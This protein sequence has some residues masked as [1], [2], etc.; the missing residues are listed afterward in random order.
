[1]VRAV[2]TA[3]RAT[4]LRVFDVEAFVLAPAMG[5]EAYR[6]ALETG[7]E[8]GATH[9]SAIGT[10]ILGSPTLLDPAQRVDLFGRLCDE[11]ARFGLHVGVGFMLY[12]D[13]RTWDEALAL[14]E[15]ARPNAGL[16]LDP[17]HL[18]RA[19]AQ[20]GSLAHLPAHRVA[21]ARL[22]DAPAAAPPLD[23]LPTEARTARL[24]LGDGAIA[25]DAFLDVLP[26][27]TPLVIETPVAAEAAWPTARRLQS[28]AA[29]AQAFFGRQTARRGAQA[30]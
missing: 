15:A 23:G 21:Y 3:L 16:I 14:I 27:R 1:M 19:G 18:F 11:A 2:K 28:V 10:E 9:I 24:H 5:M 29:N 20:P 17:L 7:A 22:C 26:E 12:R 6:P 13:I 25:L 30:G 8:L 4:G